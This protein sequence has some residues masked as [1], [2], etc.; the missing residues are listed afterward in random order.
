MLRVLATALLVGVA[1]ANQYNVLYPHYIAPAECAHGCAK[2]AD[3][4]GDGVKLNQSKVAALFANGTVPADAGA[5]CL[6]PG[7]AVSHHEGRRRLADGKPKG[8]PTESSIPYCLCQSAPGSLTPPA[9]ETGQC[10]PPMST[11]EQINLQYASADIVVAAFVTY[12]KGELSAPPQAMF[13]EEGKPTSVKQIKGIS[14]YYS[15]T[16]LDPS[17]N[18]TITRH[19]TMSFVKFDGLKPGQRYSYKVKSGAAAAAWSATFT[20]R[21]ARAAPATRLGIYGDMGVSPYNNMQ[22]LLTDCQAGKIDVVAHMGDHCYDMQM[23]DDR[24]GDAYVG[25]H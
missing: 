9:N 22:N 1:G 21:S 2:W 15:K 23:E 20:F 12:E 7:M 5:S 11:P 17:S 10:T 13:G 6:W 24:K 16:S 14:H 4:A 18:T 3:V 25:K 8:K 19:Y